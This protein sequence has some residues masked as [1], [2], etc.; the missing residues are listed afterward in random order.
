[1]DVNAAAKPGARTVAITLGGGV[2]AVPE[3][4]LPNNEVLLPTAH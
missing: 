4:T 3:I 1:M 2:V